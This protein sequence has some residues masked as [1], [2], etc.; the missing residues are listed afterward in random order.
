MVSNRITDKDAVQDKRYKIAVIVPTLNRPETLSNTVAML[1]K[2]TNQIFQ[3]I[4]V[5]QTDQTHPKVEEWKDFF[6]DRLLYLRIRKKQLPHA[7]NVS[8]RRSNAEILL[9]LDDDIELDPGVVDAHLARY[10]DDTVAAVAGRVYGAYD[11]DDRGILGLAG[12]VIGKSYRFYP[13]MVRNFHLET[14]AEN[15]EH[16]PGGH[17]SIRWFWYEALGGFDEFFR[18][19]ASIGE[20]SEFCHRLRGAISKTGKRIVFEPRASIRHL[21]VAEGGCRHP[22]WPSWVRWQCHNTTLMFLRHYRWRWLLVFLTLKLAW[23]SIFSLKRLSPLCYLAGFTGIFHGIF[24]FLASGHIT[25]NEADRT[26]VLYSS[27][28]EVK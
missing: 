10:V 24:K 1:M 21:Q 27:R 19:N 5:D 12:L 13:R 23:L 17:F 25:L 9:F 7:R 14:P 15:I 4:I 22:D 16:F 20:E 6:G 2:Q 28:D 26:E 3:L 18:G 11:V 8:A